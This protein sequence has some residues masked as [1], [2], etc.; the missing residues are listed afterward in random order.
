MERGRRG[1]G[2]DPDL[3][4][5]SHSLE[6]LENGRKPVA[7]SGFTHHKWGFRFKVLCLECVAHG[8]S[9]NTTW[10]RKVQNQDFTGANQTSMHAFMS[11]G[12]DLPVQLKSHVG[13]VK[14]QESP[15]QA[16]ALQLFV[17][18]RARNQCLNG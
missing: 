9:C 2:N 8:Q 4:A 13:R 11:K 15:N 7:G 10:S 12:L 14:P 5:V 3:S 6:A 18:S 16:H 17:P 1:G